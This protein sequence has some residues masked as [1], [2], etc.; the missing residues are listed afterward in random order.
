MITNIGKRIRIEQGNFD[1][2]RDSDSTGIVT[3]RNKKRGQ[4]IDLPG[5]RQDAERI[6]SAYLR[7]VDEDIEYR[8][9]EVE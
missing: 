5:N 2:E 3:V 9:T 8:K 4:M 1:F 6:I 7:A